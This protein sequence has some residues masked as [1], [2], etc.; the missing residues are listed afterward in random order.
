[1]TGRR[2]ARCGWRRGCTLT[3]GLSYLF[4]LNTTFKVEYRLDRADLPVFAVVK[5]GTFKKT[6]QLF[7]ASVLVSF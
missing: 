7:G 1:M 6:N 2:S 4:D 3:F 5:D